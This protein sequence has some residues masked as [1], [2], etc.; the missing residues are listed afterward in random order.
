[1]AR[2]VFAGRFTA[3]LDRPV[4]VFAIGMRINNVFDLRRWWFVVRQMPPMLADLLTHR[5]KGPLHFETF[6]SLRGVTQLQYWSSYDA[7]ERFARNP[8][9][10]HLDSWRAFNRVVGTHPSAG[11]W[12]ETYTIAPGQFE[13][14]YAN[15]PRFGMAAATEHVPVRAGRESAKER[16]RA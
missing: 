14:V 1:M 7:L 5:E 6:F 8:D 3:Q 2:D 4:V 15:M 16:L 10:P 12:H 13:G 9:D 11:I